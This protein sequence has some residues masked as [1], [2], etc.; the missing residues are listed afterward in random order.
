MRKPERLFVTLLAAVGLAVAAAT[1]A[2][3]GPPPYPTPG[4]PGCAG[5]D[6]ANFA[7]DW[8]AFS[9]EPSGVARLVRFYG[10]TNPTEWLQSERYVDCAPS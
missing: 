8:K 10:G 7:Q 4:E 5:R 2:S 6:T 9:F 1:S 3:A